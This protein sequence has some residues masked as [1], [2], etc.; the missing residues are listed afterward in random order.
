M[1]SRW[2]ALNSCL[3]SRQLRRHGFKRPSLLHSYKMSFHSQDSETKEPTHLSILFRVA[4][5]SRHSRTCSS[6]AERLLSVSFPESGKRRGCHPALP[7]D[8]LSSTTCLRERLGPL[9]GPLALLLS[10]AVQGEEILGLRIPSS[11][12]PKNGE[13]H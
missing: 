7:S 6:P 1:S 4:S 5:K 11:G 10:R 12:D 3:P 9:P 2:R 13:G 8:Y